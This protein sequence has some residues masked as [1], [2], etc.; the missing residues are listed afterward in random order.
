MGAVHDVPRDRPDVTDPITCPECEGSRGERLGPLFLACLFCAGLGIVGGANEPAE[1]RAKPPLPRLPVAF[2]WVWRDPYVASV[3]DCRMCM[4]ARTVVHLDEEA[5]ILITVP[6]LC[7][8]RP[9]CGP[10]CR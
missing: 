10:G 9:R 5:G 7:T 4:G 1:R 6:C 3:L 2:H 8:G